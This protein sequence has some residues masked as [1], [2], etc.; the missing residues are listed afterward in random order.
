[1]KNIHISTEPISVNALYTGRRFLTRNGKATKDA[2]SWEIK[3]D[4]KHD[5]IKS[6][7]VCINVLFYF[8]DNRKDIDGC[9]KA[10]LDCMQGIV[11]EN[12]RQIIELH[13]FKMIDKANP[14]VE[15]QVL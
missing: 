5:P 6:G 2:M 14:R 8:K 9:L 3:K 15:I 1:M 13:C 12:D 4:W 10:L 11:Y 7:D